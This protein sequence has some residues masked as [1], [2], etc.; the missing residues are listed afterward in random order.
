VKTE[1]L[2]VQQLNFTIHHSPFIIFL[3]SRS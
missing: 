1:S 2:K 3:G